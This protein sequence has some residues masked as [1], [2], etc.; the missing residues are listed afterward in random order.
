MAIDKNSGNSLGEIIYTSN[1]GSITGGPANY[2]Q[3]SGISF[4]TPLGSLGTGAQSLNTSAA[5]LIFSSRDSS[6]L[7]NNNA[8]VSIAGEVTNG[9]LNFSQNG[10]ASDVTVQST[11]VGSTTRNNLV[12]TNG[13]LTLHN[14]VGGVTLNQNVS[15]QGNAITI[16]ADVGPIFQGGGIISTGNTGFTHLQSTSGISGVGPN[17]S[18]HTESLVINGINSN[19]GILSITNTLVSSNLTECTGM[20]INGPG[21]ANTNRN[22]YFSQEGGASINFVGVMG[23]GTTTLLAAQSQANMRFSGNVAAGSHHISVSNKDTIIENV[24][25]GSLGNATFICDQAT[26]TAPGSSNFSS[27]GIFMIPT[28]NLAIY[29]ASGPQAPTNVIVNPPNQVTLGGAL[30]SLATWDTGK[31]QGLL[32]KYATSYSDGGPTHGPGFGTN[33]T[34]GNGVFGSFVIWYKYNPDAL[35]P[36]DVLPSVAPSSVEINTSGILRL[37]DINALV[38]RRYFINDW[39]NGP[40]RLKDSLLFNHSCD[41]EKE[42]EKEFVNTYQ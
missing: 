34:P 1:S 3:G 23:N 39:L 41:A 24:V 38:D 12:A 29:A 30:T 2:S 18:V 6:Y 5:R 37:I 20:L 27:Q 22:I 15:A 4:I 31:P 35:P 32:S 19:S 17:S 33:Y 13:D 40:Y 26:P 14:L 8:G 11:V 21:S 7:I 36:P 42:L 25:I 9:L 10:T 28:N 16:L